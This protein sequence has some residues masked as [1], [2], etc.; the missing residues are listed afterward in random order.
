MKSAAPSETGLL[1][2]ELLALSC[3]VFSGNARTVENIWI[4]AH[5]LALCLSVLRDAILMRL[6][7]D[8][9]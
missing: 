4:E 1:I 7:E 6:S 2:S 8:L 9:E 5:I 3:P